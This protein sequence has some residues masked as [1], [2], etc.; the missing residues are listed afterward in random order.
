[1]AP[2]CQSHSM[3]I[4]MDAAGRVVIPK[5]VRDRLHI[6]PGSTLELDEMGGHMEL[7]PAGREVWIDRSGARPVARAAEEAP[8]L[9]GDAVRELTDRLRR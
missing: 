1:M 9:T 5:Q 2:L 3:R 6:G 7:R 4:T 8:R